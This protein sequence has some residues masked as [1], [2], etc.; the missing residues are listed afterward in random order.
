MNEQPHT[1][2][3][4]LL[5]LSLPLSKLNENEKE[6]EEEEENGVEVEVDSVSTGIGP[7]VCPCAMTILKQCGG[8][9][10]LL[11]YVRMLRTLHSVLTIIFVF[12]I[13]IIVSSYLISNLS[14]ILFRS[15]LCYHFSFYLFAYS[16]VTSILF[17][18]SIILF[19]AYFLFTF[20]LFFV[21]LF[22]ICIYFNVIASTFIFAQ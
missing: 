1:R 15:L 21:H 8:Q 7:F 14:F 20:P 11:R 19:L 9:E 13:I 17:P 4:L 3:P 16:T 22:F 6:V 5:P 12:V 10:D 2:T 18:F